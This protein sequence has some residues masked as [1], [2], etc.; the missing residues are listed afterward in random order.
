[1]LKK[2]N[3]Y[4]LTKTNKNSFIIFKNWRFKEDNGEYLHY[5]NRRCIRMYFGNT[6]K[7]CWSLWKGKYIFLKTYIYHTGSLNKIILRFLRNSIRCC[8]YCLYLMKT[9]HLPYFNDKG[10]Y[11]NLMQISKY[12]NNTSQNYIFSSS[13][14][15]FKQRHLFIHVSMWNDTRVISIWLAQGRIYFLYYLFKKI[16]MLVYQISLRY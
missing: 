3:V 8:E 12:Y 7:H 6:D 9:Y 11:L 15:N 10:K 14:W 1:M 5:I 4:K 16:K 2:K 13:L